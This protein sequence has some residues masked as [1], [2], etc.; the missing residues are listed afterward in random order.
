MRTVEKGRGMRNMFF[1]LKNI[2][3]QVTGGISVVSPFPNYNCLV[4]RSK[5]ADYAKEAAAWA[6]EALQKHPNIKFPSYFGT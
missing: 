3:I 1:D 4:Y 5:N 6:V 2:G